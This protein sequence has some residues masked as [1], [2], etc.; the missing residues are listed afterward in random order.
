MK[1]LLSLILIAAAAFSLA[2]CVGL[3]DEFLDNSYVYI[4]GINE[5]TSDIVGNNKIYDPYTLW[6][7]FSPVKSEFEETVKI[8]YET[9]AVGLVEG[10]DYRIK[11]ESQSPLKFEPGNFTVPLRIVWLINPD[12]DETKE[13]SLTIRLYDSNLGYL[14]YGNAKFN[15]SDTFVFTKKAS[16]N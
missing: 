10:K 7:T 5:K 9:I 15:K 1:K 14:K 16:V 3:E 4:S 13:N 6:V 8:Y 2:S 12:F 11:T